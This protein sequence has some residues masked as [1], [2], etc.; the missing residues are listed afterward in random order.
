MNCQFVFVIISYK[1]KDR[2]YGG[3]EDGR[4]I[5][6]M[7]GG[8]YNSIYTHWKKSYFCYIDENGERT[9]TAEKPFLQFLSLDRNRD[10]KSTYNAPT[11]DLILFDEFI[12]DHYPPN[13]FVK[14]MDLW[15]H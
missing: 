8:V 2:I 7:T 5:K 12:S 10:Y 6:D 11:G 15:Y 13:E 4:Y 9:K 1:G 14:F 3:Q